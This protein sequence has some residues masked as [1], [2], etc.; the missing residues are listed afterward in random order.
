MTAASHGAL[1]AWRGAGQVPCGITLGLGIWQIFRL[2]GKR[3]EISAREAT[4]AVRAL[5]GRLSGLSI[6]S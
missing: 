3:T 4:L 1:R 2:E 5:P 6:L